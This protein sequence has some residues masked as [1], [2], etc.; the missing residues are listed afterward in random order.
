MADGSTQALKEVFCVLDQAKGRKV[1]SIVADVTDAVV[2]S[3]DPEMRGFS[4]SI[5]ALELCADGK[6]VF[7]TEKFLAMTDYQSDEVVRNAYSSL[8]DVSYDLAAGFDDTLG[9]A[10]SSILP[11]KKKS[12][13]TCWY[14]NDISVAEG[15]YA[16]AVS[17]VT[18][19]KRES[20][21]LSSAITKLADGDLAARLPEPSA[22]E[23]QKSHSAFNALADKLQTLLSETV[24]LS[25]LILEESGAIANGSQLLSERCE[26]QAA[27][28]EETSS[29]MDEMSSSVRSSAQSAK[30]ATDAATSAADFAQKGQ[31]IVDDAI[32]AMNKIEEGSV[33]VRKIIEVIDVIA[34]QTNLLALNA[35]VEAARAGEAGRG[36]AVVASEVR[37]LA[38]R[39]SDSARD[40]SALIESSGTQVKEGAALVNETGNAL[41]EIVDAVA[42]VSTGIEGVFAASTEQ[43][44]GVGEITQAIL[45]IDSTTQKTAAI[46]EESTASAKLLVEKAKGLQDLIQYFRIGDQ[47][48]H[49]AS[50]GKVT[51]IEEPKSLLEE[52]AQQAA[53]KPAKALP[54]PATSG[55]LA[56]QSDDDDGWDEF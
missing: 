23:W 30:D 39:A 7:A 20:D 26:Q 14:R 15:S 11:I 47:Q 10:L 48:K 37:A 27:S 38:Q 17:D 34:F 33:E 56:L 6:I 29:S 53:P 50:P 41:N 16:I 25:A 42:Q 1:V 18:D 49:Q 31:R 21:A 45:N 54:P 24:D 32:A 52:T 35:G 40:I 28:V 51:T 19:W 5:A 22:K 36:F 55:A 44:E 4:E 9:K 3:D 46:S 13:E 12:G 8:F 43:S 2:E